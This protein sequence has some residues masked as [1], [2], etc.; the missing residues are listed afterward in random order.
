VR[1]SGFWSNESGATVVE[2]AIL[3]CVVALVI[4][5]AV[6]SGLTPSAMLQRAALIAALFTTCEDGA[7]GPCQP[8]RS[9]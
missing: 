8:S 3:S 6:A 4:V 5:A 9:P 7:A 2:H 1:P